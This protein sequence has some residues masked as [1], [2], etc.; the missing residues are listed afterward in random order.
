MRLH[1]M[2]VKAPTSSWLVVLVQFVGL[3]FPVLLHRVFISRMQMFSDM[4]ES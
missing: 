3:S 4:C 2:A 1:G